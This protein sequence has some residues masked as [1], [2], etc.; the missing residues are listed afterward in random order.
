[1]VKLQGKDVYLATLEKRDCRKLHEDF[2]YDF[3]NPHK[4]LFM[5]FESA[6]KSDDFFDEIQ[7]TLREQTQIRLGI[8]LN[9]GAVVGEIAFK[10]IDKTHRSCSVGMAF[11]KIENRNKGLRQAGDEADA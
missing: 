5:G 2:E 9:D 10:D 1:M 4:P 11:A 3:G 7:R 6:E 8:F